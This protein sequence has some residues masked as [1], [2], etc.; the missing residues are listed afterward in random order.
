MTTSSSGTPPDGHRKFA[1]HPTLLFV[2]LGVVLLV[3]AVIGIP[4][5][6]ESW[7]QS[8]ARQADYEAEQRQMD[9][10]ND[11]YLQKHDPEAWKAKKE[12]EA[13]AKEIAKQL[14]EHR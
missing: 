3:A 1:E 9:A 12:R 5:G 6:I 7:M 8:N 13:L 10:A 11:I 4:A 14:K 2:T